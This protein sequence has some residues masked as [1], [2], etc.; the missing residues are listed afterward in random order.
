M[1]SM[2]DRDNKLYEIVGEILNEHKVHNLSMVEEYELY[3]FSVETENKHLD[4]DVRPRGNRV[5]VLCVF[6]F[7]VQSNAI[8]IVSMF[9]TMI[10]YYSPNY[11]LLL[12]QLNGGLYAQSNI[13]VCEAKGIDEEAVWR[14]INEVVGFALENYIQLSNYCVGK[15]P[16]DERDK[17]SWLLLSSF[18]SLNG[19]DINYKK[20]WYGTEDF[21]E[22]FVW[23]METINSFDKW[24]QKTK[25]WYVDNLPFC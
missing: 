12:N 10:N 24:C 18:D 11:T 23:K 4:V 2:E 7:R 5:E 16:A 19:D 14:E 1:Q 3:R 20:L 8:A 13:S 9:M 6:P 25:D 17:Y 15:V 21:K 22:D